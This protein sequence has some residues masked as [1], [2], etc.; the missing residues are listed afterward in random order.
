MTITTLDASKIHGR[1]VAELEG[2][3]VLFTTTGT[4]S[5]PKKCVTK[6]RCRYLITDPRIETEAA[7]KVER[8]NQAPIETGAS[9][10]NQS[11]IQDIT[12]EQANETRAAG[13]RHLYA[14]QAMLPTF[15]KIESL[16]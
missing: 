7:V 16:Q 14:R 12:H 8:S 9:E 5:I 1:E 3:E 13:P 4:S 15:T 11:L 2:T 10:M 6:R